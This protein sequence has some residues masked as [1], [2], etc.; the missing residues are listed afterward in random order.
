[1]EIQKLAITRSIKNSL[2]IEN[3]SEDIIKFTI[4]MINSTTKCN[5]TFIQTVKKLLED[6][7]ILATDINDDIKLLLE[8][9]T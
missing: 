4:D 5:T 7:I 2:Y 8:L 1:M 3:M 6:K 9:N